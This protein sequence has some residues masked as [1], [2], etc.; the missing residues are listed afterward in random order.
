MV[1]LVGVAI[2]KQTVRDTVSID[3]DARA[4]VMQAVADHYNSPLERLALRLGQSRRSIPHVRALLRK[5][6]LE[7]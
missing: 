6:R 3:R 5:T 7:N 1:L 2:P 4:I